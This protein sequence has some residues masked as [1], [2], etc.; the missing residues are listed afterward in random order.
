M[1]L[2]FLS[3]VRRAQRA[4]KKTH[5]ILEELFAKRV[6]SQISKRE[7]LKYNPAET[8]ANAHLARE[9]MHAQDFFGFEGN[10]RSLS[11]VWVGTDYVP[12]EHSCEERCFSYVPLPSFYFVARSSFRPRVACR[13]RKNEIF[14]APKFT[15]GLLRARDKR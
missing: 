4:N 1:F 8:A 7:K 3:P 11:F 12:P 13:V 14:S 6:Q 10:L 5:N 15:S 9:R 2:M